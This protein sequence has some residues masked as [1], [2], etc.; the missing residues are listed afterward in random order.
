MHEKMKSF[1]GNTRKQWTIM[2][3]HGKK[4]THARFL[5]N[6]ENFMDIR[7]VLDPHIHCLQEC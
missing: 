7:A 6:L 2:H 1:E 4:K 3:R 5:S